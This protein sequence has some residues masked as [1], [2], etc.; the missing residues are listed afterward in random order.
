[1]GMISGIIEV[2]DK[3]GATS[4]SSISN[5]NGNL[6]APSGAEGSGGSCGI[7]GRCGWGGR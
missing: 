3:T 1:M 6:F 4:Q 5:G 2:V 7:N